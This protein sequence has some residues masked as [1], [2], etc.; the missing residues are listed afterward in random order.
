[1]PSMLQYPIIRGGM[2][3]EEGASDDN[4]HEGCEGSYFVFYVSCSF[5]IMYASKLLRHTIMHA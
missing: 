1:M 5:I 2:D 3:N 4:E